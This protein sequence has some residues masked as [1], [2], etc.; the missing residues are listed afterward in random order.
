M[1]QQLACVITDDEPIALEILEDYIKMV[2]GLTLVAKCANAMETMDVLRKNKIDILFIDIRMPGIS[3]VEF[4]R[5]LRSQPA[6]IFTTAFPDYAIDGFE[7]DALDYLLKPVS[8]E[9]FLRAVNKAFARNVKIDQT[10]DMTAQQTEG[11]N[12]L[13]VKSTNSLIKLTYD[14][15][16]FIEGLEN[17]IKIFC[18]DRVIISLCTMKNIEETL[19]N[20]PFLRIHRSYIVNLNKVD[21]VQNNIFKIGDRQ[22]LVG[23]SYKKVV[24]E[25]LKTYHL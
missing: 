13:F 10:A 14:E 4:V 9:R 19:P 23:K 20:F 11:K 2:P 5:S 1:S 3:G 7:L 17:Y 12:I 6:V 15:I 25:V 24:S 8:V 16:L 21:L 18:R 22:L